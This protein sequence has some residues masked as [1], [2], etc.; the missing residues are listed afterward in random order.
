MRKSIQPDK[1]EKIASSFP[2][3]NITWLMTGDGDMLSPNGKPLIADIQTTQIYAK[4]LAEDIEA[5][6][7][8]LNK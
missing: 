8:A 7:D 6:F 3:L 2:D 1:A 5:G 4:V